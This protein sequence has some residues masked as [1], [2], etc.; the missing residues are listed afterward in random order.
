MEPLSATPLAVSG[1]ME[2]LRNRPVAMPDARHGDLRK[3]AEEFEAMAI[4]EMLRPMFETIPDDP[5]FGGG[6]G[7]KMFRSL[8]INEYGKAISG[9]GGIGLADNIHAALI[10]AQAAASVGQTRE[11][12]G[13]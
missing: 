6:P 5:M 1:A 12:T 8:L 2:Q 13:A 3:A 7:E 9:K 10:E 11:E 4:A